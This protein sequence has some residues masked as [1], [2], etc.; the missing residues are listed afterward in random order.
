MPS[1]TL[2]ERLIVSFAVSRQRNPNS[3]FKTIPSFPDKLLIN[4]MTEHMFVYN[5]IASSQIY[6]IGER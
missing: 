6:K 1:Y 3:N 4:Q 2:Y 5:G